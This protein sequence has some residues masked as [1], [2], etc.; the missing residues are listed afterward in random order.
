MA[1]QDADLLKV[2]VGQVS[3]DRDIDSILGKA[4][5]VAGLVIAPDHQQVLA[6]RAVLSGWVVVNAAVA[7]VQAINDGITYRRTALDDPPA[8]LKKMGLRG[9]LGNLRRH[10]L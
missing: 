10:G 9:L 1:E 6:R 3:K 7:N 2:L 8:H 5:G 4:L